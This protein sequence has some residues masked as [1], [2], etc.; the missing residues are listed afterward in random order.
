MTSS[1][2]ISEWLD[3]I[4]K[5]LLRCTILGFVLILL[6]FGVYHFAPGMLRGDFFGLSAHEVSLI[7]YCGIGLLK[8]TVLL[9]F[10]FPWLS[11]RLVLRKRR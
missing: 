5:V 9:L 10:F 1:D 8:V 2:A 7:Q 3:A 11:I 4:S 6:W